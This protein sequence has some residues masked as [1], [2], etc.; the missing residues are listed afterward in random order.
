M[1][2]WDG[3]LEKYTAVLVVRGVATPTIDTRRR[4]LNRFGAWLKARKPRPAL[5]EI[6]ADLVV[7]YMRERSAFHSRSTVSGVL[8]DLRCMGEFLVQEELNSIHIRW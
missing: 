5:E 1:R 3:L 4:E 8:S 7:R 2:R 6:D